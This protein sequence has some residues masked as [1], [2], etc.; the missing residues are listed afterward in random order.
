MAQFQTKTAETPLGWYQSKS[1][2]TRLT[3]SQPY[4]SWCASD[5][6]IVAI[7]RPPLTLYTLMKMHI[8]LTVLHTFLMELV[9]RNYL[10]I[11]SSYPWWSLSLFSSLVNVWTSSDNVKRNFIFVTIRAQR[12]KALRQYFQFL[13]CSLLC[14]TWV[15]KVWYKLALTFESANEILN[16]NESYWAVH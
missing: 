13:W 3:F 7:E 5:F 8:L 10:N 2:L 12:V 4:K 9:R 14:Y 6:C 11:E 16:C 1:R 15:C